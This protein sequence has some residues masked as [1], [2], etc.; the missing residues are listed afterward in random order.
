MDCKTAQN[1]LEAYLDNELD[2]TAA[3]ELESHADSCADCSAMLGRLDELRRA[4]RDQG[5]RYRAPPG[6][7]ERIRATAASTGVQPRW[8]TRWS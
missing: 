5:L 8:R 1:L 7:H 3:R 2:R 4:L 6:L